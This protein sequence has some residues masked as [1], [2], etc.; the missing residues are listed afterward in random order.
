M[1][2]SRAKRWTATGFKSNKQRHWRQR[3]TRYLVNWSWIKAVLSAAVKSLREMEVERRT[4]GRGGGGGCG[5]GRGGEGALS[6][7]LM[8]AGERKTRFG[9]WE[10]EL[11][12]VQGGI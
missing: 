8:D 10:K 9:G 7:K 12:A 3:E 5:G 2:L 6:S 1:E 11:A 4:R